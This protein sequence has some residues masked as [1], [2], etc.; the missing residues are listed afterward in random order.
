MYMC[1]CVCVCVCVYVCVCMCVCVYVYVCVGTIDWRMKV[2]SVGLSVV[3]VG[4]SNA[5][6]PITATDPPHLS[7]VIC[8]LPQLP[9]D[10]YLNPIRALSACQ[11]SHRD[12]PH[13]A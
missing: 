4:H 3:M 13:Q 8:V 10:P 11:L 12:D 7:G 1:V 2:R 9:N 5:D 6:Q